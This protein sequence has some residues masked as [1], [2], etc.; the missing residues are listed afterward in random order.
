MIDA[1]PLSPSTRAMLTKWMP[2]LI[3]IGLAW[4]I[5]RGIRKLFWTGFGLF[6]AFWWAAPWLLR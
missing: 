4:L 2:V 6:C 3:A 5:A 1:S